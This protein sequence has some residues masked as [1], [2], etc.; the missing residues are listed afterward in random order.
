MT[1]IEKLVNTIVL[2]FIPPVVLF[3]IFWFGLYLLFPE[4]KLIPFS[5]VG[6]ILGIMIDF[7]FMKRWL[8]SFYEWPIWILLLL[9][10]FY[11]IGMIGFFMGMPVFNSLL[12]I[13]AGYYFGHRL[14]KSNIN[15]EKK[16]KIVFR[17]AFSSSF[18]ML[19]ICILSG[20]LAI[21]S[22]STAHEIKSMLGL[23]FNISKGLLIVGI[24]IGGIGLIAFT[25]L[26][27]LFTMRKII[28]LKKQKPNQSEY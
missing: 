22:P 23:N 2:G 19:L 24:F 6:L 12:G 28:S 10:T 8:D 1:K 15:E 3:V 13:L 16:K 11:H 21:S 5:I 14:S 20:S 7:I 25:C 18:A 26:T 27:S 9:F 17:V 4:S